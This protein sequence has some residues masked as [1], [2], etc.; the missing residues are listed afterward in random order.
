M[1]TGHFFIAAREASGQQTYRARDAATGAALE[2]PFHS[3]SPAD[4]ELACAAAAAACDAFR[5]SDVERRARFLEAIAANIEALGDELIVRAMAETG[6]PRARLEG[7]RARTASQLRLFAAV[8][9]QG[10]WLGLRIDTAQPERT[11]RRPE[12]RLRKI[13][14]GPVA[15][16]GASNFPLAFSVAG[17]D[18]ASALAAGCPVVVRGHPAHPGVGELVARAIARAVVDGGWPA[19]VFSYVSGPAHDVGTAL[20]ANPHIKAVG[21][22]GSRAGGLAL[23]AVAAARP[24]PIPVFAEMSSVNP[25]FL[26]PGAL[27]HDA[28]GIAKGFVA[29]L[30]QGA[31]Q[32]CTNPGLLFAAAGPELDRFVAAAAD[33][34]CACAPQ[35][36][37]TS[38]IH[39][40]YESSVA[41]LSG[42]AGVEARGR[43]QAA[44]SPGQACGA[45]FV[46]DAD[47]FA[48]NPRLAQEV[49]GPAA[50]LV[51]AARADALPALVD[52]L[53]GQLSATIHL[54]D[55]DLALAA[56]LLPALERKV[57]R[58]IANGWPTGVE[59]A[60][61]MVHG[62]PFPATT[63]S[64]TTSVG[65]LAI[66]R[67]LRP[68]CYQDVPD[69][70]LPSVLRDG[71]G[72][73]DRL[74]DGMHVGRAA[75]RRP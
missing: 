49:F 55:A 24:E 58:I 40:A 67:F 45:L 46:A 13:A 66:E 42:A 23:S 68:V 14:V 30:T 44:T 65:S 37:L 9:R 69:A 16:F 29:S 10:D 4:I 36:M 22:T 15:V 26:L 59:V 21:F 61:A 18:T 3:A 5:D 54:R 53:E 62:G 60:H 75:D 27:Q 35:T 17:G 7:E 34:L 11:P 38:G 71:D 47:A 70:L 57:G 51:R 63:D 72:K 2:P 39:A 52:S 64:R 6:L 73:F 48:R 19:G 12:L 1:I 28:E 50:V 43:G 8:L 41:W 56:R 20:V 74:V 25:V 33:A 32:F 31:G